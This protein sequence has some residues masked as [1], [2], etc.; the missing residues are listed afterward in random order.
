MGSALLLLTIFILWSSV[1]VDSAQSQ[2]PNTKLRPRRI[3]ETLW[4]NA[5][6]KAEDAGLNLSVLCHPIIEYWNAEKQQTLSNQ[7]LL[8]LSTNQT[9]NHSLSLNETKVNLTEPEPLMWVHNKTIAKTLSL[10]TTLLDEYGAVV[11]NLGHVCQLLPRVLWINQSSDAKQYGLN[12]TVI[13]IPF[14]QT[15]SVNATELEDA[16]KVYRTVFPT[17]TMV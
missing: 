13:C 5:T 14:R 9:F 1:E 17:A 4:I 11:I 12:T 8:K 16:L 7:E 3:G 2:P 10:N 6:F 15:G